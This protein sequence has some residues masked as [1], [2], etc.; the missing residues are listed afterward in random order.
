ME[1]NP[2]LP[3][4]VQEVVGSVF[5]K[6]AETISCVIC[7]WNQSITVQNWE[8]RIQHNLDIFSYAHIYTDKLC[9]GGNVAAG[10]IVLKYYVDNSVV[11]L[12][13]K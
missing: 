3:A 1:T 4:P 10:R 2:V 11:L 9:F 12:I 13:L 5:L 6:L 8:E 7:Q